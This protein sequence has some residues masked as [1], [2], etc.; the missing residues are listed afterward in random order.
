[1]LQL[2]DVTSWWIPLEHVVLMGTAEYS[3]VPL[4]EQREDLH[5]WE[6]KPFGIAGR[7]HPVDSDIM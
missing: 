3:G 2:G 7:C 5:R 6:R 4:N 1:M